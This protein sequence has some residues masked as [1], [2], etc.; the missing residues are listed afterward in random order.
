MFPQ[1]MK[2][3]NLSLNKLKQIEKM[4][5]IKNYK[6]MSKERLL[7]AIYESE[8]AVSGNNFDNARKKRLEKILTN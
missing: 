6:N 5:R 2:M 7:S 1:G 4:R 8:S 3:L